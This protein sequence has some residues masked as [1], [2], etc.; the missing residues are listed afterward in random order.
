MKKTEFKS[1]DEYIAS[2]PEPHQGIL[3]RLRTTIRKAVP[4]AE[5]LLSY[6]IPTYKLHGRP[7][8]PG[9]RNRMLRTS[10]RFLT[11]L[12]SPSGLDPAFNFGLPVT[13]E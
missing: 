10:V 11:I 3:E 7:L 6:N 9:Q 12:R 2:R 4:K 5:E 13:R 8:W 1:V